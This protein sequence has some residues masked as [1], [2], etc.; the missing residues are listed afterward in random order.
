ME[1]IIRDAIVTHMIVNNRFSKVQHGFIR[2]RSC[3]TQLWEF[4][5]DVSQALDN[6]EEVDVIYLNCKAFD[7][8]PHLHLLKK[9]SAYGV[10]DKVYGWI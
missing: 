10:Q 8:V 6:G 1:R 3:T 2:G 7:K 4:I 9:I 5:E